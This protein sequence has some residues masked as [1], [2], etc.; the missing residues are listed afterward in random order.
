MNRFSV[1]SVAWGDP[2]NAYVGITDEQNQVVCLVSPLADVMTVA[3]VA[4]FTERADRI[5]L[6]LELT[7]GIPTEL[8]REA[9]EHFF[10]IEERA[11]VLRH[12]RLAWYNAHRA[13]RAPLRHIR[14][15]MNEPV[16]ADE[17]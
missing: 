6:A 13:N 3:E 14:P 8:L 7:D 17:L 12:L 11:A 16:E 10:S 9:H 5:R 1:S 4:S 15:G 2:E